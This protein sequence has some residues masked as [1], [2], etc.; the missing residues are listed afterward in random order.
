MINAQHRQTG[1]ASQGT[2]VLTPLE[3]RILALTGQ[4]TYA[5]KS[6]AGYVGLG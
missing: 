4:E 6:K 3:Q 5:G 2:R 1:G